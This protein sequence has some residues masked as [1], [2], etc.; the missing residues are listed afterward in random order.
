MLQM[1]MY[2]LKLYGNYYCDDLSMEQ[3]VRSII[4][5]QTILCGRVISTGIDYYPLFPPRPNS[6][7]WK[8]VFSSE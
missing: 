5:L 2:L 3:E 6:F 4:S 8:S 1:P 7:R